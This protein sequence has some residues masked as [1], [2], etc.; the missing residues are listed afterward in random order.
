MVL[1]VAGGGSW[2]GHGCPELGGKRTL[3]S[4]PKDPRRGARQGSVDLG[5]QSVREAGE[6]KAQTWSPGWGDPGGGGSIAGCA[7]SL[8]P[9]PEPPVRALS[10]PEDGH[11]VRIQ[12]A[13]S[14]TL[15]R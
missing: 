1:V 4:A 15:G 2:G 12:L 3:S 9:L 5:G 6:R 14:L 7:I 13:L 10:L 11:G 8:G